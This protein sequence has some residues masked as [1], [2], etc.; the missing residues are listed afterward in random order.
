[1]R[2][3]HCRFPLAAPGSEPSRTRRARRGRPQL[4][5][6]VIGAQHLIQ[7]SGLIIEFNLG[8]RRTCPMPDLAGD[9]GHK[10][11]LGRRDFLAGQARQGLQERA[12]A[13][14]AAP[15][16]S[17]GKKRTAEPRSCPAD[18]TLKAGNIAADVVDLNT[19]SQQP[20]MSVT[21]DFASQDQPDAVQ[22]SER[23]VQ[24]SCNVL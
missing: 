11:A 15:Y 23:Q 7:E 20:G 8:D 24:L 4:Q 2:P 18:V 5:L 22:I 16:R 1:M 19:H 10:P 13:L 6:R 17:Y 9:T 12:L 3:G 21:I 14:P